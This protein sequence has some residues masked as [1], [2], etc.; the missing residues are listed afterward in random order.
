MGRSCGDAFLHIGIEF[1]ALGIGGIAGV[2]EPGIGDEPP[3]EIVERLVALY[4]VRECAT[5]L[6]SI[7]ELRKLPLVVLLESRAFG[8][9]AIEIAL[10]LRI[11]QAKV[12]I[13]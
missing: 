2:D 10:H 12:E 1:G 11:V 3:K 6:R 4:G 13:R 7:R 5:S 9:G 8:I